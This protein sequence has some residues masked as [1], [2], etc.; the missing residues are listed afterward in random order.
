[1]PQNVNVKNNTFCLF[2][3]IS[4][5]REIVAEDTDKVTL[6]INGFCIFGGADIK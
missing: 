2:G 5:K 1:M 3:G 6:T 4:D